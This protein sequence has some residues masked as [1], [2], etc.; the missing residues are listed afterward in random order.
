MSL[1]RPPRKA[2]EVDQD[3]A[4]CNV[5]G[6]PCIDMRINQAT[7]CDVHFDAWLKLPRN[8]DVGGQV[9]MAAFIADA[10]A[11]QSRVA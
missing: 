5:C 9:A 1:K 4:A 8:R 11:S 6:A 7:L 3:Q 2:V 10:K